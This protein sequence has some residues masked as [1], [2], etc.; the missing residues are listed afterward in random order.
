MVPRLKHRRLQICIQE[1][2]PTAYVA[3]LSLNQEHTEDADAGFGLVVHPD[4]N[5]APTATEDTAQLTTAWQ[6][7]K[8]YH[9]HKLKPKSKSRRSSTFF[10]NLFGSSG[11]DSDGN[12]TVADDEDEEEGDDEEQDFETE[13]FE[14]FGSADDFADDIGIFISFIPDGLSS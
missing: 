2:D 13:G 8:R 7:V 12:S 10:T 9:T 11:D 4:K 5:N 14:Y 6:L 3:L 1:E